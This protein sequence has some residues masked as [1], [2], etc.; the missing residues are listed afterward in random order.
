MDT[1]LYKCQTTHCQTTPLTSWNVRW[2]V[3]P[4]T[5]SATVKRAIIFKALNMDKVVCLQETHW[6]QADAAR[7]AALFPDATVCASPARTGPAGS[8]QGGVAVI[9]NGSYRLEE[10]S[11][12]VPGCAINVS[13]SKEGKQSTFCSLYL[14]PDMRHTTLRALLDH[15][16]VSPDQHLCGDFNFNVFEPRNQEELSLRGLAAMVL[17]NAGAS[18]L[19]NPGNTRAGR[20]SNSAIDGIAIPSHLAWRMEAASNWLPGVSDHAALSIVPAA[21]KKAPL[22]CKPHTLRAHPTGSV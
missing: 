5:H 22:A 21:K 14:P 1:L 12:L 15:S 17:N 2:L 7:W 20:H 13:L 10:Q 11:V 3:S 19:E 18:F 8:P 16:W 6:S 9:F 4:N